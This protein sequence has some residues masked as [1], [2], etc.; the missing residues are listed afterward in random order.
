MRT[1][2]VALRYAAM[3]LMRYDSDAQRRILFC[4]SDG[5]PSGGREDGVAY[6]RRKAEEARN[7][8]VEVYGIGIQNAYD[9]ATGEALFGRDAY[10]ILPDVETAGRIIGAFITRS[11]NRM[12]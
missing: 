9:N 11:V 10:C 2:T 6:N 1:L 3:E 7:L 12:K 5:L 4:I 8:G